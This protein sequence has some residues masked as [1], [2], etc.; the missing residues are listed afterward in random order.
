MEDLRME[1]ELV[2]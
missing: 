2:G 1:S